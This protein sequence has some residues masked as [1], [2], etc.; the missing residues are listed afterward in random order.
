MG[1]AG[2]I[3]ARAQVHLVILIGELETIRALPILA[4]M[5]PILLSLPA[6]D[7]TE[8]ATLRDNPGKA[9]QGLALL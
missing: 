9:K 2:P 4:A 3:T 5:L 8:F 6:N 1:V 7:K